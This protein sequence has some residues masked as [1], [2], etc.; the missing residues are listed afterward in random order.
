MLKETAASRDICVVDD[1][2]SVRDSLATAL[3]VEGYRVET[4]ADGHSFIART[5]QKGPP[6]AILLDVHMPGRSGLDILRDLKRRECLTPVI[7]ITGHG[8][9]PMA[10]EAIKAGAYDFIEKPFAFDL[11]LSQI[12][13][14]IDAD[15]ADGMNHAEGDTRPGFTDVL[16]QREREVLR[17]IA[18]GSSSKEAG[19]FLGISPRTVEVHRARIMRKLNA[20]N[21]ADLMRIVFSGSH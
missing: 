13:S 11:L 10:V 5:E 4:Y 21:A 17:E 14:A 7:V 16:T 9:V 8:D 2:A 15:A 3:G 19:R 1:D 12:K 18:A 6:G 20:R